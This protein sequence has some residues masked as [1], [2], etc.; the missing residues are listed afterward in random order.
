MDTALADVAE[1]AEEVAAGQKEVARRAR[2]M[3]RRR[4]QGWTWGRI[5]DEE[6][7]PGLLDLL[8]RSGRRLTEATGGL[9]R[10]LA[11]GLRA[12]GSSRRHIARRLGVTH[13]RVS[14]MLNG[15]RRSAPGGEDLAREG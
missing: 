11:E 3:Q 13:Q 2:A 8:R 7:S 5:L 12:E 9:A 15:R 10:A 4:D 6:R 14:A 1:A